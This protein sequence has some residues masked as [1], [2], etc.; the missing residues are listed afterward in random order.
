[1]ETRR[2]LAGAARLASLDGAGLDLRLRALTLFLLLLGPRLTLHR[3]VHEEQPVV[4]AGDGAAHEEQV[5]VR[6]HPDDEQVLDRHRV[7][8]HVAGEVLALPH[9]ARRLALADGADVPVVLVSRGAVARRAL[10]APALEDAL[11]PAALGRAGHVDALVELDR[12]STR[13]NSSH[14]E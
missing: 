3:A 6:V 12:K 9:L 8:A 7:D 4:V 2:P 5:L 11:E 1:M 10:H 13:L 14:V